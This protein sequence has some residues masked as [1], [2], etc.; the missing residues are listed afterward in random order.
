MKQN[1]F[2]PSTEFVNRERSSAFLEDVRS[3]HN[4]ATTAASKGV[5]KTITEQDTTQAMVMIQDVLENAKDIPV[6][7]GKTTKK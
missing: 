3:V 6:N 7:A 4:E 1:F 5:E 2:T